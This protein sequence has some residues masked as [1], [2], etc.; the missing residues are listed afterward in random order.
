MTSTS[1]QETIST[2]IEQARS[3][4]RQGE[5]RDAIDIANRLLKQYRNHPGI[6]SLFCEINS[7]QGKHEEAIENAK[8]AV[9]SLPE[10]I[11]SL[12]QLARCFVTAGKTV[13]AIP[14][15]ESAAALEPEEAALNDMIGTMFSLCDE[16]S[17]ALF[18]NQKAADIEP[19]NAFYRANLALVQRMVGDLEN[20]ERNF[21][22]VIDLESHNYQ[23]YFARADLKRWTTEHN[24]VEQMKSLLLS[25]IDNWR[26]EVSVRY[27]LAKEYEDIGNYSETFKYVKSA[28]DLQRRHTR[29]AVD[30]D[31]EAINQIIKSHTAN[32]LN[33]IN[34]G[35]ESPE[36]IFIMGLPRTGTTLVDRILSSHSDVYSAG[37]LNNFSTMMVKIVQEDHGNRRLNMTELIDKSLQM[38]AALLGKTYIDS[39]R[40]KTGQT[41]NF[42]DKLPLNYLYCGLI[43]AA[44][45]NSKIVLLNRHPMDACFAIYRTMFIGIYPFSNDLL[46]LGNYYLAYTKLI[47]HWREVLGDSL[48]VLNYEDLVSDIEAQVKQLLKYCNLEW[49]DRCLAFHNNEA[50]STTA[51]AV[52]VRQPIYSSSVGKWKHYE[53][54]LKPLA[55]LFREHGLLTE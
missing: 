17:K 46:D 25:G 50:P 36:P 5:L 49:D 26:G 34:T 30:T 7:T 48:Y 4:L 20:A 43:R 35:Y 1:N 16:N 29:Y 53:E 44:L 3:A 33:N 9:K 38:D 13:D 21:D 27:A 52:Q 32:A 47:K 22:H 12:L 55:D 8:Q 51:S 39:T 19:D 24:H 40:P 42:T 28:G 54:E 2:A 11:P 10:H 15:I 31:V 14:V 18:Y 23:A 41:A 6:W 37:E 45:P